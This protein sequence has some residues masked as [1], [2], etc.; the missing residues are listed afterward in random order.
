MRLIF[1]GTP[2]P[3]V[4]ALEKLIASD[5]EVVAVLTRPDAR[6]GRGRALHPSPV[7]Q[8]AIDNGI[9][10]LRPH[11][12]KAGTEDGDEFRAAL[13]RL[14]PDCV[15]VVAY[16]NMIPSDLLDAVPFGFINLHFSLL[17][18][19]RGAAPVQAAIAAGDRLTG[20]STFR[21][22]EGLDTG[23]LIDTVEYP[24]IGTE[25]A[26]E[27][28]AHLS[29]LGADLLV[30][31]VDQLASG[32]ALL[33]PQEGSVTHAAKINVANARVDWALSAAHI[34]RHIRA[35]LPTPGPWTM[36]G[37][38]RI[39][40][41]RVHLCEDHAAYSLAPGELLI[42]KRRVLV[43]TG[44][45]SVALTEVQ[46]PGKKMMNAADWARGLSTT[47]GLVMQ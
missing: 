35:H 38:D 5:H 46:A 32:T 6:Q 8:L 25:T 23:A 15:P 20:A 12:L 43:G 3:A 1:A 39:K 36:L 10:V 29:D 4:G 9:E 21:I 26:G 33:K 27:L 22:D 24:M 30:S 11:T 2:E 34:D 7:A 42:E 18:R 13:S 44:S 47:E 17:P 16:G 37:A 45:G 41:G 31:S 14:N 40:L 19:W 28:L